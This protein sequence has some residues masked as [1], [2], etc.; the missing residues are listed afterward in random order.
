MLTICPSYADD[1]LTIAVSGQV[2]HQDIETILFPAIE[3]KLLDHACIRLWYEFSADFM[4][5]TVGALWD[6]AL[7]SVFHFSDFARVV[8]IADTQM[9]GAMVNTLA[10][11]LPCPVKVFGEN[12]RVLAKEWLDDDK[13][14]AL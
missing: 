11:M 13:V 4:G 8:M 9:L 3:A 7:L 12:E 10:F 1:L 2:T 5:V 14:I 6:D